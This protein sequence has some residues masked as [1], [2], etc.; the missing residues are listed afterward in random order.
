MSSSES[1]YVPDEHEDVDK[2]GSFAI[3]SEITPW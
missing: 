3:P 1:N 2:Y